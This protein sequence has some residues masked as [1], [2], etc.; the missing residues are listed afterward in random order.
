MGHLGG[1]GDNS[2]K[3]ADEMSFSTCMMSG[4]LGVTWQIFDSTAAPSGLRIIWGKSYMKA[5]AS[6]FW[7]MNG[8]STLAE[9]GPVLESQLN[10]SSMHTSTGACVS[11]CFSALSLPLYVMYE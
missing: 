6:D 7:V 10:G 5:E 2:W 8:D 9:S 3:S 1:G 4:R 11:V